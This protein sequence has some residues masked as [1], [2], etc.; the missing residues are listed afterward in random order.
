MQLVISNK[1]NLHH[2]VLQQLH[3]SLNLPNSEILL[4]FTNCCSKAFYKFLFEIF[5][6]T[7]YGVSV[8]V[9]RIVRYVME[10]YGRQFVE[11][12]YRSE[13]KLVVDYNQFLLA[14]L[15]GKGHAKLSLTYECLMCT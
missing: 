6:F 8:V 5:D 13:S 7:I 14:T 4:L 10:T 9:R 2:F 11:P 1:K 12:G 15:Y 3:L